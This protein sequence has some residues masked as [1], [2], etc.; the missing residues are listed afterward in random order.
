M[1][2][3]YKL[4]LFTLIIVLAATYGIY[5]IN[6][7]TISVAQLTQQ[8]ISNM[9]FQNNKNMLDIS[10]GLE[11]NLY[12]SK[13]IVYS[14]KDSVLSNP[15][16]N[17]YNIGICNISYKNKAYNIE[18]NDFTVFKD[19]NEFA[20]SEEY[21]KKTNVFT[22]LGFY[23][24]N[25]DRSI[26]AGRVNDNG[27]KEIKITFVNGEVIEPIINNNG[28]FIIVYDQNKILKDKKSDFSY[29]EIID[30]ITA[31]DVNNKPLRRIRFI[32]KP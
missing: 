22:Q 16:I 31:Y 1:K 9:I 21:I 18:T 12:N 2:I 10:I 19:G 25:T 27:V 5:H 32:L 8:D 28:Y 3:N 4:I 26:I 15:Q 17:K 13:Y 11:E 24:K 30:N 14:F 7:R 20:N 6:N 29:E 23:D